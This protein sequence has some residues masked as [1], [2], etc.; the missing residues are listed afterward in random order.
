VLNVTAPGLHAGH[1]ALEE[2][3]GELSV[4]SL[5]LCS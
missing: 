4:S 2:S 1:V 5:F 3:H